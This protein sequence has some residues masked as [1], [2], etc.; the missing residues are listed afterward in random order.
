MFSS[1]LFNAIAQALQL[2]RQNHEAVILVLICLWHCNITPVW[3]RR[4]WL[5]ECTMALVL[6]SCWVWSQSFLSVSISIFLN[7]KAQHFH[8]NCSCQ[9]S[10]QLSFCAQTGKNPICMK[11]PKRSESS[12]LQL[13]I[14]YYKFFEN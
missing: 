3:K 4:I 10:I 7:I 6:Q 5:H 8:G 2:G 1:S 11:I 12:F 14:K 9:L 13:G